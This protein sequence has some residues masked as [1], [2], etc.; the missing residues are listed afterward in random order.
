MYARL[1]SLKAQRAAINAE[2]D[3]ELASPSPCSLRLRSLKRQRLRLKD[4]MH[5]IMRR[6]DGRAQL[7]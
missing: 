4:A 5:H 3:E 2:I 7:A 1:T 6:L